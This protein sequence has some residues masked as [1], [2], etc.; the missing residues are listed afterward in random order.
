MLTI[1]CG[2]ID[3]LA[4]DVSNAQW[5]SI[6]I[7]SFFFLERKGF[8]TGHACNEKSKL[9]SACVKDLPPRKFRQLEANLPR[10]QVNSGDCQRGRLV[11]QVDQ[12]G[13]QEQTVQLRERPFRYCYAQLL[14]KSA[15][16]LQIIDTKG[17]RKCD[18]YLISESAQYRSFCLHATG[19]TSLIAWFC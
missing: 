18:M 19:S 2:A 1:T 7:P 6:A 15:Q 11:G 16:C 10:C 3:W 4:L 17:V 5:W 9:F 13:A 14:L 8:H 12:L